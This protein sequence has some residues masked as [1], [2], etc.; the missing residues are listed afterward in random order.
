MRT[1]VFALLDGTVCGEGAGPRTIRPSVQN[2]LVASGDPVA[3]D[4]IAA[5]VMGLDPHSM[6]LFRRCAESGLGAIDPGAMDLRGED[7]GDVAAVDLPATGAAVWMERVA[8][9]RGGVARRLSRAMQE[10][11]WFPLVGRSVR[12][13]YARTPWGRLH[14]SYRAE[15]KR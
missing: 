2:V 7:L 9:G 4:V 3:A 6:P 13:R 5:R 1:R 10:A 12:R 14:S 15:A 8:S 11:I